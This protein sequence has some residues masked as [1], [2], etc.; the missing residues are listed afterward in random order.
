MELKLIE[1]QF[2]GHLHLGQY[3]LN[4]EQELNDEECDA[5]KA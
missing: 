1:F 5:R 4:G 3:E 2:I